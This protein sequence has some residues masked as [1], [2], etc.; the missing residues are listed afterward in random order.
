MIHNKFYCIGN[1]G[2]KIALFSD[3][4]YDRKYDI[5]KFDLIIENLNE[6]KPDFICLVGDIIDDSFIIQDECMNQLKSFIK[7]LS[8]IAPTIITLGNHDVSNKINHQRIVGNMEAINDWFLNLNTIEN[9]YY[10]YNKSIIRNELCFTSYNPPFEYYGSRQENTKLFSSDIDEKITLKPNYYNILL[11][12]SPIS[13]FKPETLQKSKE[14][15][16]VDL[17]LSGH[18]HNGLVFKIFDWKGN[19]GFVS[20]I[21]TVFPKY[22]R[23]LSLKKLEKKQ[24]YLVVSGGVIKLSNTNSRL[25]SRFNKLYPISIDYITI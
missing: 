20:P 5:T 8:L 15:K 4:H 1:L 23:G 7:R 10:L 14:I 19:R 22:A 13:V 11:C 2:Y 21:K 16:K 18:M 17:I 3:I 12:H 24:I 25:L 9:V 6:N